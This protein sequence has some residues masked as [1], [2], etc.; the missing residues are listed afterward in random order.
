MRHAASA[1][2]ASISATCFGAAADSTSCPVLGHEHVVLDADA[3]AAER[4]GHVLGVGGHVEPRLDR[5]HHAGLERPRRA[6]DRVAAD[7][8][9]VAA[10]PVARAVHVEAP[11][12]LLLDRLVDRARRAGRAR[13]APRPGRGARCVCTRLERDARPDGGDRGELRGEHGL[14]EVALRGRCSG[15]RPGRCA[16]RRRSSRARSAPASMRQ[17]LVRRRVRGR[18][19]M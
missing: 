14:V 8:V 4:R 9:H 10:E 11:V 1:R 18:C 17:Q 3:D 13:P 16:S 12:E 7:V 2:S 19:S 15:G 6:V 5:E